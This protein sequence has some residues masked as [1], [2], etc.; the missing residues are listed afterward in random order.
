LFSPQSVWAAFPSQAEE[1]S[2]PCR[3]SGCACTG[4]RRRTSSPRVAAD[5][6]DLGLSLPQSQLDDALGRWSSWAAGTRA[7]PGLSF[8]S[9]DAP[10]WLG[11]SPLPAS[12]AAAGFS[13]C[14][15]QL[16]RH[17]VECAARIE[18]A[19]RCGGR[20]FRS[21]K[22]V[23]EHCADG[24]RSLYHERTIPPSGDVRSRRDAILVVLSADGT[25]S[26]RGASRWLAC[27]RSTPAWPHGLARALDGRGRMAEHGFGHDLASTRSGTAVAASLRRRAPVFRQATPRARRPGNP[28]NSGFALIHNDPR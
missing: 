27:E 25:L 24:A 15:R 6:S 16:S 21:R 10:P 7:F 20:G 19:R 11:R 5:H 12:A 18:R 17:R 4:C 28:E 9:R 2:H 22:R 8:E 13:T 26:T 14:W 23:A 1:R 3:S